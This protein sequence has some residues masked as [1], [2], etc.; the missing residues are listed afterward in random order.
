MTTKLIHR[1]A[2][3]VQ[4]TDATTTTLAT[5]AL[6]D[7]SISHVMIVVVA[8]RPSNGDS[9]AYRSVASFKRHAAGAAALVGGVTALSTHEDA[10]AA[11]WTA[12]QDANA[13]DCRVRIVGQ[14]AATIEWF[15]HYEITQYVP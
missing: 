12:T 14:A 10:G 8:R 4:T 6:P 13:N 15:V 5:I 11:G 9:A 2:A 1:G 7:A 3:V